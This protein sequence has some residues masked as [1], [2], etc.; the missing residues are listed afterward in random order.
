V[1]VTAAWGWSADPA[2]V[3]NATLIQAARIFKRRTS[4]E[5]VVGG[6]QDFGAVRVSS[7]MDPDV[8]DL[9]APYRR[10]SSFGIL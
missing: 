1:Q 3:V 9:L 4:P 5:G 8:M 7:R 6:F 10:A 2:A